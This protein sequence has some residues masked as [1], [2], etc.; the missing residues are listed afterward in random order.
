MSIVSR[1]L[2]S[3]ANQVLAICRIADVVHVAFGGVHGGTL[4]IN[5]VHSSILVM[6][7]DGSRRS[8]NIEHH[9]DSRVVHLLENVVEPREFKLSF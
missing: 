7:P 9:L 3:K 6:E 2:I 5:H 1:Q 8:A 4:L